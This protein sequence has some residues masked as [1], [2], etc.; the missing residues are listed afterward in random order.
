M[1]VTVLTSHDEATWADVVGRPGSSL[2]A[3]AGRLA[4][5]AMAAGLDGV[6]SSPLET[7]ALRAAL[8]PAA[9]L[10]TPG[11]RGAGDPPGD[12]ARTATAAAAVE[13]GSTHLV[14]GRPVLGADDPGAACRALVRQL[15]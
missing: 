11:I 6:V 4:A 2:G 5:R 15:R 8:G 7:A 9:L 3:E 13:A 10:V 1:V 14:V 12:Q